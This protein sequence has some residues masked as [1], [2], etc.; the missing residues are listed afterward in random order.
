MDQLRKREPVNPS[1]QFKLECHASFL[2]HPENSS[3]G[4]GDEGDEGGRC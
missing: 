1:S 4:E 2:I 3:R